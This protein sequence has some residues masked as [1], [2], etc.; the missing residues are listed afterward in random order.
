LLALVIWFILKKR[1]DVRKRLIEEEGVAKGF[2]T[3]ETE[4]EIEVDIANLDLTDLENDKFIY[5]L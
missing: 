2:V 3:D 5:P 4:G 1:N